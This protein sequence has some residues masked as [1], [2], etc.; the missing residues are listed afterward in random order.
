MAQQVAGIR[1]LAHAHSARV[2]P[3]VHVHDFV[4]CTHVALTAETVAARRTLIFTETQVYGVRV[5]DHIRACTECTRAMLA[6]EWPLVGV[7]AKNVCAKYTHSRKCHRAHGAFVRSF[8]GVRVCVYS[9][10]RWRREC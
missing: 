2:C 8:A 4:M 5:L 9:E 1:E 7:S 6:F 10:F 3:F